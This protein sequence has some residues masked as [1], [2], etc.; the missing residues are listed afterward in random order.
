MGLLGFTFFN[1][2]IDYLLIGGLLSFPLMMLGDAFPNALPNKP[3]TML[4]IF[5]VVNGA[6]FAA[7]TVR[8]YTKE[9]VAK[10]NPIASIYAPL[11]CIALLVWALYSKP[12]T[13]QITNVYLI[14][15]PY[16]YA[17][18]TFGLATIYSFRSGCKLLQQ[19]RRYL[20]WICML[21]FMAALLSPRTGI[22]WFAPTKFAANG[23]I[24]EASVYLVLKVLNVAMLLLPTILFFGIRKRGEK[25]PLIA[26]VLIG[27]NAAW[28]MY[29]DYRQAWWWAA[30]FHSMQYLFIVLKFHVDENFSSVTK[31]EVRNI[32]AMRFYLISLVGAFMIFFALPEVLSR[33]GFE[34][35][36]AYLMVAYL[37]NIHH[38]FVDGYIWKKRPA[39]VV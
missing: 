25:F 23:F 37:V 21:P 24:S 30:L 26:L 36:T 34:L 9:G 19:E 6:H 33:F 4:A 1:P 35:V 15:S 39:K 11:V 29:L 28:W 3:E 8:L 22:F 2:F 14:W 13:T 18:Q 16:H 27:T 17:A 20:W 5:L 32:A 10:A 7:S 38:F 31:K 12:V